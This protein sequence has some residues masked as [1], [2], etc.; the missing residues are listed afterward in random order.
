MPTRHFRLLSVSAALVTALIASMP[1]SAAAAIR[2]PWNTQLLR[3][4]GAEAGSATD[5]YHNI[6]VPGWTAYGG[7]TVV[8]YG[9]PGGFPTLAESAR[10]NGSKK[11]F[12]T[13]YVQPLS[14]C[15]DNEAVQM[16]TIN[17]RNR[18]IDSGHVKVVLT[19]RLGT[20]GSQTDTAVLDLEIGNQAQFL[21]KTRTHTNGELQKVSMSLILKSGERSI[22]VTMRIFTPEGYCDA[23][24][25]NLVLKIVRV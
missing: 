18:A 10:I 21:E 22:A 16:L 24:F 25:D 14:S 15:N 8:K 2:T 20:Y 1:G 7:F 5:G 11:F 17:G 23:Y 4:G 9:E 13:G 12:T 19:G 6:L 3:N